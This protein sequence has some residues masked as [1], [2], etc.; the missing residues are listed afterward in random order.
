MTIEQ[1]IKKLHP[2]MDDAMIA[3][4]VGNRALL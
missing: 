3:E 4:T 1:A 2:E